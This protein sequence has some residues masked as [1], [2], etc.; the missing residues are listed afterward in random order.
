MALPP[1]Y[2][3]VATTE[4]CEVLPPPS[5]CVTTTGS[6]L[7]VNAARSIVTVPGPPAALRLKLL[8]DDGGVGPKLDL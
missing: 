7:A 2:G 1:A 8:H 3:I 5:V 4:N 6:P